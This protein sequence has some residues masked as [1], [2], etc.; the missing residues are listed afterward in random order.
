[1]CHFC[2]IIYKCLVI[3]VVVNQTKKMNEIEVSNH[4]GCRE[5]PQMLNLFIHLFI[6][7]FICLSVYQS[8]LSPSLDKN[9]L[10]PE[11]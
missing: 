10:S 1:M 3:F 4:Q 7:L 11:F 9:K 5:S 2:S 6:H 8:I